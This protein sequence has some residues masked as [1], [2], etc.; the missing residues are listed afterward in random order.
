MPE[1][2]RGQADA[3]M[4]EPKR[5]QADAVAAVEND[6]A[7]R[8]KGPGTARW[9]DYWIVLKT[10][11][12]LLNTLGMTAMTF[13]MGGMAFWMPR[14][15]SKVRQAGSLEDVNLYFGIIVVVAGLGATILGGWAGDA[16]KRRFSGSYFL[17]SAAAMLLGFP[18]VLLVLWLPFP[19]AWIFVFLAC[20]CLFFNTGPT[21]AILAN[22]THPAVRASAFAM[23]ILVIHALGD[24]VSPTI[25]GFINGF[26]GS[27][28]VGFLTVSV[29]YVLAAVCWLCGARY[30]EEDTRMAPS[31]L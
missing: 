26:A 31:R 21:N 23:N 20:F 14:Y 29:M 18:M 10:P 27:M 16:L 24:A 2:K 25:I 4:P 6:M 5:G 1:P 30:L 9:H 3:V 28:T 13:A 8:E 19:L 12:Y 11:S 22:V 15:V 7:R 17:V